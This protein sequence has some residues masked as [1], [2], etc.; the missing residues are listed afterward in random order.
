[1]RT[2]G[3]A[4]GGLFCERFAINDMACATSRNHRKRQ[5]TEPPPAIYGFC[6]HVILL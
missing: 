3:G 4:A 5:F 6:S 1:M 2:W